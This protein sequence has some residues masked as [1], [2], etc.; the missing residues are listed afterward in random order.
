MK[1]YID[2]IQKILKEGKKV[3]TRTGIQAY[4]IA[5]AIFE[6]DMS[7]GFPLLT[8]KKTPFKLI[9][10]ELEFF[11]N[12][13]TDKQWLQAKNNHIWDE[14]AKPQKAPYGHD[15]EAKKKMLEE[16]D[17]GPIYGFQWRH[18]NAPYENYD[19]NYTGKGIDQLKNII[20]TLKTDPRDR[21]MIVS[22]WNPLQFNEMALPPCHYA[23][24]VTV[25]DGKLNLLWNQ[26]SVD[27]ML[28]LPFNIASYALFL[29]L[30]AKEANL[31]E[32]K[33]VG[34]LS[35]V[36]IYENHLE[37]V[38]EQLSRDY[39]KYPLPKIETENWKSI[40]DWHSEDTK[41]LNYQSYDKIPFEIAV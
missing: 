41:L 16:R 11:I 20:E 34:F 18:F 21:R 31:Q 33:L 9:A 37:G 10:S 29:H 8:T 24:Q 27:T 1:A 23:F 39:N 13:I 35:D 19:S 32:G 4:T 25:I 28:G 17:L 22:A 14:W 38:K 12:G 7:N 15:Q 3:E 36:H 30:L 2:I 40:F 6:H 5:G 26:R